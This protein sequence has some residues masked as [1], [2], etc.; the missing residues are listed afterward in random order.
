[1]FGLFSGERVSSTYSIAVDE[2]HDVPRPAERSWVRSSGVDVNKSQQLRR[3]PR[4]VI[5][6]M[7]G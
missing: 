5:W 7:K 3:S 1:M 4:R 2:H 6:S